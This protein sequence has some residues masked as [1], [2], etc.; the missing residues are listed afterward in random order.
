GN[1]RIA[2][3]VM[4][5]ALGSPFPTVSIKIYDLD[6]N[7]EVSS[8]QTIDLQGTS[9][10]PAYPKGLEFDKTGRYLYFTHEPSIELP[11]YLEVWDVQSGDYAS[12]FTIPS[13]FSPFKDSY[14]ERNDEK[15]YVVST[16][17]IGELSNV[18]TPDMISFDS[19]LVN[20]NNGYG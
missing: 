14:I 19:D 10:T 1:Y 7:F 4:N 9:T 5:A 17:K 11:N 3:P 13:N 6:T 18:S 20:I 8:E 16:E 12:G 2:V 15:L